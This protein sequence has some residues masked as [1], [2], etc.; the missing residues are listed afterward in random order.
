MDNKDPRMMTVTQVC[1]M[2]DV[3]PNTLR[4]WA[5]QGALPVYR[6]GLGGHRRFLRAD[7]LRFMLESRVKR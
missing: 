1:R 4:R 3:H 2:L 6:I 5:D 7:V